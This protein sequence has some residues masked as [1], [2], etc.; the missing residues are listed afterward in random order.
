MPEATFQW[1]A[2]SAPNARRYDDIWFLDADNGWAVNSDGEILHTTDGGVSW[3]RQHQLPNGVYPRCIAFATPQCGWVGTLT[4]SLRMLKTTDG[5]TNWAE[6]DNLPADAPSKICG[7]SVVSEQVVFGSGTNIP[8]DTPGFI[9]TTDGGDTWQARD[10]SDHASILI[11]CHFTS[12]EVGWVV[13]GRADVANPSSR[14]NVKPI[15]LHTTD[16]GETWV[17]LLAGQEDQFPPGEWGWKIFFLN[18]RVGYVSLEN[19]TEA[20]ILRTD[21][22]GQTWVRKSINDPQMNANL[23]GIGFLDEN[24]GWVG[25]WGDISFQSGKSSATIDGGDNWTD[26]NEIGRFINRFRFIG[27]PL[28]VGYASGDTVY[29][30]S[31]DPVPTPLLQDPPQLLATRESATCGC[32]SE[33]GCTVPADTRSLRV[34]VWDSFGEEVGCHIQARPHTGRHAVPATMLASL[35]DCPER[36]HFIV[37]FTAEDSAGERISE[38]LVVTVETLPSNSLDT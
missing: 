38:S 25:G 24:N 14:S 8:R 36:N 9:K 21:D 19:F 34:D 4:P 12:P 32:L 27:D 31:T 26:A 29:K 20:A 28:E 3:P 16:G 1:R 7:L 18:D 5:G 15:V 13:G 17:N 23:E 6:V 35:A 30:Y 22:G 33:I 37:R 11:D 10:M 2:T